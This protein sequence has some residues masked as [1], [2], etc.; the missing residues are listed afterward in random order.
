M[1]A[2]DDYWAFWKNFKITSTVVFRLDIDLKAQLFC[3]SYYI[4]KKENEIYSLSRN[5]VND[6]VHCITF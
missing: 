6:R 4:G 5:V 1:E 3:Y 2:K